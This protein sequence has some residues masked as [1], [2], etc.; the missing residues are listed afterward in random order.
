MAAYVISEVKI[1][2]EDAANHYRK[3][4]ASSIAQLYLFSEEKKRVREGF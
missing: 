4:A 3:L 2:N 1:I